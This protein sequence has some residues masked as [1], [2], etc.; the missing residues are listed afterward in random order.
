MGPIDRRQFLRRTAVLGAAGWTGHWWMADGGRALARSLATV[1]DPTGTT[2]EATIVPIGAG[3]Y[4]TLGEGPGWPFVVRTELAE[5][6]AGREDRRVGLASI[7]HLT[8]IHVIDTQS[9]TRVEFLDRYADP[10]TGSI[11]FA[12]AFRAQ[13][14][15]TTQVGESMV[16]RIN[17]IGAGPVTG[18]AFDCAVS[19]G[20]N[21]DN[22]QENETDWFFALLD[23]GPLTP[24]SGGPA[25]EG[26]Q[27]V[28]PVSS[29]PD[30]HYWH[31]ELPAPNSDNYKQFWGFPAYP[32]LLAA[33][34]APFTATG[35]D[36]PWYST[37]GNHDGLLSGN[38]PENP[39]VE[40]ISTGS[41]KV[42]GPPI[43]FSPGDFQAALSAGDPTAFPAVIAGAGT[44]A[45]PTTPDA[46]RRFLNPTE[47][48]ER[49]L[50][51]S[52][53][54]GPAGHGYTEQHAAE[55]T[56]YFTFPIAPGV[57]GVS[58][59]TVN[60]GG[61]ADGSIGA[62]QLAWLE[63]RVQEVSSRWFDGA[64]AEVKRPETADQLVVLFSHHNL[65]T[66]GNPFPDPAKPD[67]QRLMA[68][69]IEEVLHRYPNIVG[70]VNGHSHVNRIYPRP[71]PAGR[72][73][74]F[75]EINTA[76]HVD[77]PEHARL[78]EVVDNRDGTISIF[79]TLIE[80][81]APAATQVGATD[82]IGLAAISRELAVNE[83]Q[84][85]PLDRLGAAGDRNV[86]LV[87]R[88]PFVLG[89]T[90][91]PAPAATAAPRLPATGSRLDARLAVGG[92]ALGA[93]LAL[94]RRSPA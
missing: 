48:V 71:D 76:A 77:Y 52:S 43:G 66:L 32:G 78:V 67:D 56:L 42:V 12:S 23:G 31:P 70:W 54:P 51:P 60:R 79:A 36:V 47:W 3:P 7:V 2:L 29:L 92:A 25:Y 68:A 18:R 91:T 28:D 6:K 20:D 39:V 88:A 49:H 44:S 81:A 55:Q 4:V 64:G 58:L 16:R 30:V 40:A 75:W 69:A 80:H 50:E 59:D 83:F 17:Q 93:A 24:N 72:T 27:T 63:A 41:I 86:E 61:Y 90:A 15:L 5:P 8:D 14:T 53:G 89:T 94:R 62:E 65:G 35:L 33:A 57:L 38:A 26:V 19:T 84:D 87:L 9:P 85:N 21:I 1:V 13:E 45:R 22:Q 10:P 74:G 37:Y 11:P 34:V 73:Q 82:P 46:A